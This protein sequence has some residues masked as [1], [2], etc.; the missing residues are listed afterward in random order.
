MRLGLPEVWGSVLRFDA[1]TTVFWG[2]PRRRSCA[3]S[4]PSRRAADEVPSCAEAGVLGALCGQ[5]GSVMATEVVKLVTGT[6]ESLLGRVLVIDALRGR[7]SEV[8]LIGTADTHPSPLARRSAC[9]TSPSPPPP[10]S[11]PG[12]PRA[13]P[14]PTTSCS[15]TCASPAEF[16]AGAIPG[17]VLVPLGSVLDGSALDGLP[18][19]QEIVVQCQVG[20][21][22]LTAARVLRGLGYDAS[23]LDGGILAW[24]AAADRATHST[25]TAPPPSRWPSRSPAVERGA[26]RAR[27]DGPRAGRPQ[28]RVPAAL[29]Q[30]GDGRLRGAR[31]GRRGR[32]SRCG[33][34]RSS[35][36]GSDDEPVVD[37][38]T[39]AR[40]MTG[41]PVPPGADAI[42]PVEDT[43]GGTVDRD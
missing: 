19:D 15:S 16:A 13:R 10:S 32:A 18:R 37:A 36:A 3:T 22:S 8:P 5:V 40:I 2:A 35:P 17:A 24:Y 7:W 14:A 29:G 42:V 25:T 20:G 12:S 6:G 11:S 33:W 26:R 43:D 21:R 34:S 23:N 1:Q 38:G 28:R 31:G 9:P 30:L 27:R 4:S 41:A 39:A